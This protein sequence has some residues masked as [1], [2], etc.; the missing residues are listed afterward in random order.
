MS[1]NNPDENYL[2]FVYRR[3]PEVHWIVEPSEDD[4]GEEESGDGS[5]VAESGDVSAV[6]ESGDGPAGCGRDLVI[7]HVRRRGL[8]HTIAQKVFGKPEIGHIHL[9][10]MGS[11]IWKQIDGRRSVYDIGLLL[12]EEFGDEA[13]PLF[14]R[15]AMYMKNL[16]AQGYIIRV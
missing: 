3:N 1:R 10:P 16:D 5:A 13:E 7:L 8:G 11:F 14:E 4:Y 6:A 2:E 15:L 12:R 9:E